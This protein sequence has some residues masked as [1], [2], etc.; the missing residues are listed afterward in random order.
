MVLL[1]GLIGCEPVTPGGDILGADGGELL[2]GTGFDTGMSEEL[3]EVAL[4][5]PAG[6]RGGGAEHPCLDGLGHL[7][8]EVGGQHTGEGRDGIGSDFVNNR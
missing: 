6:M 3:V 4:I 7:L 1:V 8:A 2:P 5:R